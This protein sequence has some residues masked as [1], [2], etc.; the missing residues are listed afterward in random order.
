MT[1]SNFANPPTVFRPSEKDGEIQVTLKEAGYDANACMQCGVCTASCLSG[2]WTS[3]R[4]RDIMRRAAL[5]DSTVLEDPDIWLCTTCYACYDRCPRDL[6]VT[7]AIVQLR[8]LA[9]ARG[10]I[11]PKH[12]KTVDILHKTGH[13]VPINDK[14]K[15]IRKELGLEEVPPTAYRYPE[16]LDKM[17]KLLFQLV[18]SEGE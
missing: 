4:T 1:D 8:N 12:R 2:R 15:Q 9:A 7:D 16:E 5:G 13:A 11:N 14:I 17:A 3:M 6:K 10:L 18:D